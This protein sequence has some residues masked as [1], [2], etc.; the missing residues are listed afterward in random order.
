MFD[1]YLITSEKIEDR[2]R[3]PEKL[4]NV[5]KKIQS[6]LIE[7]SSEFPLVHSVFKSKELKEETSFVTIDNVE[8]YIEGN[9]YYYDNYDS[10]RNKIH[11]KSY[12]DNYEKID[13]YIDVKPEIKIN[14]ITYF[15]KSIT[16]ADQFE[17]EFNACFN[18][19][20]QAIKTNKKVLWEFG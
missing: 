2:E 15:T 11:I 8:A 19:L 3:S 1:D 20:E 9:L 17:S 12:H 16:K 13:F 18:F 6:Q 5:L 7:K 10:V 4:K 14:N